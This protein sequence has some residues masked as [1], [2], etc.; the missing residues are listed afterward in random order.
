MRNALSFISVAMVLL[1]SSASTAGMVPFR[2]L[3]MRI[4]LGIITVM[5]VMFT[6]ANSL[7]GL[8]P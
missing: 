4:A 7:I 2:V 1:V 8:V 6:T 3:T 5:L